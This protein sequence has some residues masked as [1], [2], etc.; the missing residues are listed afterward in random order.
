MEVHV[1]SGRQVVFI[2]LSS[3]ANRDVA[4]S[5]THAPVSSCRSLRLTMPTHE[6][7]RVSGN[8]AAWHV[9]YCT[10][11]GD[12][13]RALLSVGTARRRTVLRC[14]DDLDRRT[15]QLRLTT[16]PMNF[17]DSSTALATLAG[18]DGTRCLCGEGDGTG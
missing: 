16:S 9:H 10:N 15:A 13:C 8:L 11:G 2:S 7:D 17:G 1:S 6:P 12:P 3:R 4:T 18:P 14:R 5:S